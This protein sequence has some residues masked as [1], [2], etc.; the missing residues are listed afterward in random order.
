MATTG[1]IALTTDQLPIV[2]KGPSISHLP[3]PVIA[4]NYSSEIFNATDDGQ[5][6]PTHTPIVLRGAVTA[7]PVHPVYRM[8]S[9][10]VDDIPPDSAPIVARG[11]ITSGRPRPSVMAVGFETVPD[12]PLPVIVS[13]ALIRR[14][15]PTPVQVGGFDPTLPELAPTF[16]RVISTRPAPL[17]TIIRPRS[18]EEIAEDVQP[19]LIRIPTFK[20]P[21]VTGIVFVVPPRATTF[22][23]DARAIDAGIDPRMV[24]FF[25]GVRATGVEAEPRKLTFLVKP[26][27][28]S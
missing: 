14:P 9:G 13:R 15:T 20:L 21:L 3:H 19:F 11:A 4:A 22:I 10:R 25:A 8:M 16:V 12:D 17:P 1:D 27:G 23:V 5:I 6:F 2:L 26:T 24:T 7:T 18:I 28:I